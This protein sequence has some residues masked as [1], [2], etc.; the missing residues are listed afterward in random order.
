MSV[1]EEG[2]SSLSPDAQQLSTLHFLTPGSSLGLPG[3]P[4]LAQ[5]LGG[6]AAVRPS[7]HLLKQSYLCL[8]E[9]PS[10]GISCPRAMGLRQQIRAGVNVKVITILL[11]YMLMTPRN[12]DN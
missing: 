9:T 5:C 1:I 7:S 11:K 10:R 4:V 2:L 12:S 6:W 3:A 8:P